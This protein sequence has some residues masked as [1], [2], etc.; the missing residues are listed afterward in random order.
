MSITFKKLWHLLI[1]L[2]M[3]KKELVEKTGLSW[4][5]LAKMK[6]GETVTTE[7]IMRICKA[8]DCQPG[9]IMEFVPEY[10]QGERDTKS[11]ETPGRKN[12]LGLV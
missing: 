6:K 9:D 4:S 5:V 8:L 1:E 7:T 2:D 11:K 10:T 12:P 3:N